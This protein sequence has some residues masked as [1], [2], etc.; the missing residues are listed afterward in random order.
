MYYEDNDQEAYLEYVKMRNE[1]LKEQSRIETERDEKEK[2]AIKEQMAIYNETYG[3]Y[4][5]RDKYSDFCNDIKTSLVE[6]ALNVLFEKCVGSINMS[7]ISDDT[8]NFNRSLV[9]GYIKENGA[10]NLIESFK[11]K[12]A[13]L[14]ELAYIIEN[15]Y[16]SILEEVD[17][18]EESTYIVSKDEE[19]FFENIKSDDTVEDLCDIIRT[20]VAND[21][22]DFMD[23]NRYQKDEI[24]NSMLDIEERINAVKLGSEELDEQARYDLALESE[25]IKERILS[26]PISVMEAIFHNITQSIISNDVLKEQYCNESGQIDNDNI[27]EKTS[28][29]Y[30]FL[31]MLEGF[32]IQ[33]IDEEFLMTELGYN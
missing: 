21:T 29:R 10:T 12:T 9:A 6:T 13:L 2:L 32:R 27:F 18:N 33:H 1:Q 28:M 3:D 5:A 4:D 17:Q 22:T 25:I 31:Q 19:N 30:T 20:R 16:K 23:S 11:G 24:T 15:S 14:S 7:I 26:R 8:K